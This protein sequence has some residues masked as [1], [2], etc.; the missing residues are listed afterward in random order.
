MI[1]SM[2]SGFLVALII[3]LSLSLFDCENIFFCEF[4]WNG[5]DV[6]ADLFK[7]SARWTLLVYDYIDV[8]VFYFFDC[9]Y[10]VFAFF[11][12]IMDYHITPTR[13]ANSGEGV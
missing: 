12:V 5:N 2:I 10:Q 6:V 8:V 9:E 11:L 7:I 1:H 13:T 4:F 3:I